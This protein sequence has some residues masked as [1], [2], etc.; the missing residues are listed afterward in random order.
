M[1][2]CRSVVKG[3][4]IALPLT[5]AMDEMALLKSHVHREGP[6]ASK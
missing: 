1:A 3:G 5:E 2:M 4:Q 6:A